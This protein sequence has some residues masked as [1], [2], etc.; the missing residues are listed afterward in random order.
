MVENIRSRRL[1]VAFRRAYP[2]PMC[3]GYTQ[4]NYKRIKRQPFCQDSFVN[5]F[6]FAFHL[7]RGVCK[8]CQ[9]RG[10]VGEREESVQ[11]GAFT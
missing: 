3:T 7:L 1:S 9:G 8:G 2:L 4:K 11:T 6:S 10:R 5:G